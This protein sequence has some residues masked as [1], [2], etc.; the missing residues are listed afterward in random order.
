MG[1]LAWFAACLFSPGRACGADPLRISVYATASDVSRH[2]LQS[3]KRDRVIEVLQTLRVSRVFLEGRRGDEYAPAQY[4]EQARQFL[5]SKGIHS[6]GGIA[7]VPGEE[8]GTRQTGALTWLNWESPA[9]RSGITGFFSESSLA[10]DELI[11]DDFYCTADMSEASTAARG[12]RTWS[13]YRRDLMVS[14][15]P[16]L[17]LE[18]A[19]KANPQI[20]LIIKFPQWYDRFH[21]FGY[22]PA[23]LA[24]MFDQVW[25]GTEVRNPLTRRMGYVQPT[26]GYVNFRWLSSVTGG[27]TVGAWFDHI[28]C[29]PE[30]FIDQAF[31]SVLAGARE[32]TL[33]NLG[34]VAGEHPGDKLLARRMPEL[35]ELSDK[36]RSHV[37]RGVAFYKP[38]SSEADD[39]LY[40][41]DYLAMIGLPILPVSEFPA[42]AKVAFLSA[43]AAT[44][45]NCLAKTKALLK[46]GATVVMT[47]AFIRKAG[48]EAAQLAGVSCGA[49]VSPVETTSVRIGRKA[50]A[51]P[52]P[53]QMDGA[54]TSIVARMRAETTDSKPLPLLTT[55][56]A[57]GGRVLVLNVRTF[58]EEDFKSVREWLLPPLPRG[59]SDVPM[60][61][62]M[63]LRTELASPL[64][65]VLE[66][67]SRVACL[68]FEGARCY[69]NFHDE[70]IQVRFKGKAH[71]L[72]GHSWLWVTGDR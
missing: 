31:L 36:V 41:A 29:T 22:D 32:L 57:S 66:G 3:P 59:L 13:E 44:D 51:L 4:L 16:S 25:V 43:Q 53:L 67:P 65:V 72:P 28:E 18:P 1:L 20:R 12:G 61:L 54:V 26:Q 35:F 39:N 6:S 47:P 56:R 69:Y 45:A 52:A 34:D 63:L 30:N 62:A 50:V 14:L 24:P 23:R 42:E 49:E 8:F 48:P 55:H 33:F 10:F 7:T 71:S 9:T 64:G 70:T 17:M 58:S 5:A 40:L 68:M 38:P 15:V 46:R 37:P 60:E 21:L 11:V 19:R 27:K 2:L